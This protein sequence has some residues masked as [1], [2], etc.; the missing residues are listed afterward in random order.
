MLDYE[1]E[2]EGRMANLHSSHIILSYLAIPWLRQVCNSHNSERKE[3]AASKGKGDAMCGDWKGM[4]EQRHGVGGLDTNPIPRM[5]W[6][7]VGVDPS[8][9]RGL[10]VRF[11]PPAIIK[12]LKDMF[13]CSRAI[14]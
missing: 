3:R 1:P 11:H 2:H 12:S 9:G 6:T 13:S 5:Q 8:V 4:A 7:S 14:S 10:L